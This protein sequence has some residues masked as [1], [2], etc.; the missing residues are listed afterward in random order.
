MISVKLSYTRSELVSQPSLN[1]LFIRTTFFPCGLLSTIDLFAVITA[2][3]LSHTS[4]QS[5]GNI[6]SLTLVPILLKKKYED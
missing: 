4:F 3:H 6:T 5:V 1:G 2:S